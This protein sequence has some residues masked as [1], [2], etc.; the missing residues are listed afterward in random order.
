[1]CVKECL[2][3]KEVPVEIIDQTVWKLKNKDVLSV[4]ILWRNKDV[5]GST[6]ESEA[7]MMNCSCY[8][9]PF[10]LAQGI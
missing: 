9:F 4:K 8:I 10:I 3:S 1:M 6:W 7:D 2:T 5:E